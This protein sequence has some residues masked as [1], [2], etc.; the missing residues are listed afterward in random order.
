M[1]HFH[2]C[3]GA[4]TQLRVQCGAFNLAMC[5]RKYVSI[6]VDVRRLW[7]S[8]RCSY[9][10]HHPLPFQLPT[11]VSNGPAQ[12]RKQHAMTCLPS[13]ACLQSQLVCRCAVCHALTGQAEIRSTCQDPVCLLES[14][15]SFSRMTTSGGHSLCSDSSF[16]SGCCKMHGGIGAEGSLSIASS[17]STSSPQLRSRARPRV[18]LK[19]TLAVIA[20]V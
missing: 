6:E 4:L 7:I 12:P 10:P 16:Q 9:C 5:T 1:F 14:N 3:I 8:D 15:S 11:H 17:A 2:L 18:R 13:S 19:A 20:E